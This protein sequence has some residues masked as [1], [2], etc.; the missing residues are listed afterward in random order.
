MYCEINLSSIIRCNL[1]LSV[2]VFS[3]T[4]ELDKEASVITPELL[5]NGLMKM[6]IRHNSFISNKH[7]KWHA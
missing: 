6:K 3:C 2:V 5:N 1:L 4:E 7:E